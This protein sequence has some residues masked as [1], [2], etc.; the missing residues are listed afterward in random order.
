[1]FHFSGHGDQEPDDDGDEKDGE[2]ETITPLD[3]QQSGDI[4]DDEINDIIVRPLV[5]GVRLHA[6][7]DA[8]R[9]GTV[10]DLPN[11]CQIKKYHDTIRS[12]Y[13]PCIIHLIVL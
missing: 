12:L 5:H 2:D 4:R 13:V 1:V 7:I 8:C 3:W 11:L 9:S 6:I 10:L